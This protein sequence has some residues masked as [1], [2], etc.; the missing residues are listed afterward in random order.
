MLADK[1]VRITHELLFTC[2][3]SIQTLSIHTLHRY[4]WINHELMT[5]G[6]IIRLA[7]SQN[8]PL[9]AAGSIER[10]HGQLQV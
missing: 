4:V 7:G 3:L 9:T 6:D 8:P 2:G 5:W 10:L 1:Y